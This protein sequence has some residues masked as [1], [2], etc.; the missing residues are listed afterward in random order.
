[1]T[2][3]EVVGQLFMVGFE[4]K[5]FNDKTVKHLQEIKP[6]FVI[7]FARNI[8]SPKQLYQLV[9]DVRKVLGNDV[10]FAIDQ[11]G[12]IV[13]RL[14]DGFAVSPGAMALAATKDD[15][16]A[17]V[18]GQIL[19]EEMRTF[20]ITWNLA[21]VVDINDNPNNP[22]I[23]VR[24]FGDSPEK[25]VRFAQAFYKG[26]ASRKVA[27]CA[28]HFPGKGSVNV[29]AHLDMPVLEKSLDELL[30]WE[31]VPF[32]EL[33]KTGI[34]SIMPSH[35]YLPKLQNEKIPATI[36]H[37]IVTDLL[38]K[39]LNFQGVIIADDLLMGGITKNLS[40]EEAVVKALQ[41]G[42]DVLTVCHEPD[43]QLA[44]K[45]YLMK[46]IE[47]EPLLMNRVTESFE[48]I[49]RFKNEFG[50]KELPAELNFDPTQHQ[51]I[52]EQISQKSITLVKDP[53]QMVPVQLEKDDFV[54]TVK[55]SRLV[56]VEETEPGVPWVAKEL[57][58]VFKA[59][60]VVHQQN[61]P[62]P[63]ISG[64]RCVV[65]TENA[66]LQQ[67]QKSLVEHLRKRFEKL[68]IVAMRNPYDCFIVEAS[69]LCSYGY[70]LVSQKALFKVLLGQ[71]K[72][73]G[74]LPVE[75]LR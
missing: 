37:E 60:L 48:R 30:S 61:Q 44:A 32:I 63:E 25:V 71:E 4:G 7:L 13:T 68:L 6:G 28:K 33:I 11:E 67:W 9:K 23:G 51:K 19:A 70:E 69:G 17:F 49:K 36:S 47:K 45:K 64:K 20:G 66:H 74:K 5:E 12:G 8:E 54:V 58:K 26:L 15:N 16:N 40:V 18:A 21:P 2:L 27:A 42:V 65:F 52:M 38:R 50:V 3:S 46:M 10:V 55:T 53:D 62:L 56:Q 72:P 39:R 14:R 59:K 34:P 43:L 73:M 31:L 29:D 35:I 75:V 24:S 57:S 22:E 41:A 1:M